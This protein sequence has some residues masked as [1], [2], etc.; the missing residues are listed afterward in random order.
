MYVDIGV[1]AVF[2]ALVTQLA[3][4]TDTKNEPPSAAAVSA[5]CVFNI[6]A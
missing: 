6:S 4:P 3:C 1:Y 5:M 2:G